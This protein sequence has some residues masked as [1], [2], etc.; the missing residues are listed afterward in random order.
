ML[1]VGSADQ[2]DFAEISAEVDLRTA[3]D[4]MTRANRRA[5]AT[6]SPQS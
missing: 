3:L 2:V 4:A 1:P 6:R 5:A